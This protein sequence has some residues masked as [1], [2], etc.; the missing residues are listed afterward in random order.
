MNYKHPVMMLYLTTDPEP[1]EPLA[2]NEK[3]QQH[4]EPK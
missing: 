2:M 3:K 4:N 1:V